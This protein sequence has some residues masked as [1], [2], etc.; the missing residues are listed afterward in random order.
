MKT[1]KERRE[2]VIKNYKEGYNYGLYVLQ[3]YAII[4][5]SFGVNKPFTS[6]ELFKAIEERVLGPSDMPFRKFD[7]IDELR[8]MK[9]LIKENDSCIITDYFE[10]YVK[11]NDKFIVRK[12]HDF[13]IIY[14][15]FNDTMK[16]GI[17]YFSY[18]KHNIGDVVYVTGKYEGK[19]GK[20][21]SIEKNLV[22]K[23]HLESVI[24]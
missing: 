10:K 23:H 8:K 6:A 15:A 7:Y 24:D 4:Y 1:E 19:Q 5:N 2:Y 17:P 9:V 18:K 16:K 13:Y 22:P 11:D 21:L 3:V 12:K 20:I 14:V